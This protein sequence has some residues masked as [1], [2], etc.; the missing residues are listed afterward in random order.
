M[1]I[2]LVPVE[3]IELVW[4]KIQGYMERAAKYT[5]GRFLAEDIKS[6]LFTR[7]NTQQLWIAF[8]GSDFYGAYV[9]EIV[10]YPRLKTCVIHFLG[11]KQFKK[12]GW[13]GLEI[14]QKFATEQGCEVMESFGRPGWGKI[15]KDDG[16]V[17]RYT[18]YEL[19]VGK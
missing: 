19:P 7:S 8:E 5:Y 1:Q 14:L 4:P 10:Q 6:D 3:H 11:G 15:W 13:L 2:S 12:W 9:T 17:P 18:L 16:Y